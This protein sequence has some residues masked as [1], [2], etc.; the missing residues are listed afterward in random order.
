MDL[1]LKSRPEHWLRKMISELCLVQ[2]FF[3]VV[4]SGHEAGLQVLGGWKLASGASRPAGN[5][6]V[7]LIGMGIFRQLDP[8][9]VSEVLRSRSH[10]VISSY[11]LHIG[12]VVFWL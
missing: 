8:A 5:V 1:T 12:I 7:F 2:G 4:L 10:V 9:A 11:R 3:D 6:D